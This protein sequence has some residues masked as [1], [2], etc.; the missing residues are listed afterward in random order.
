MFSQ[1]GLEASR[2]A[3]KNAVFIISSLLQI[4]YLQDFPRNMIY[5]SWNDGD[6]DRGVVAWWRGRNVPRPKKWGEGGGKEA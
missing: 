6:G 3:F 2:G 1:K 4:F 5:R